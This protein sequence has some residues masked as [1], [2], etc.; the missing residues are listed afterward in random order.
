VTTVHESLAAFVRAVAACR[1]N[2]SQVPGESLPQVCADTPLNKLSAGRGI[3]HLYLSFDKINHKHKYKGKLGFC[4]REAFSLAS[5]DPIF[6]YCEGYAS[7]EALSI[8]LHHA[9]CVNRET[10]E[11]Y[12]PVWN[13]KKVRGNAYCGLPFN[14]KFA[15]EVVLKTKMYGVL[16]MLWSCGQ[17]TLAT[18]ISDIIHPAYHSVFLGD[19]V[20]NQ[21]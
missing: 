14:I 8:P 9:W 19:S 7:S 17:D 16:D 13:S 2:M 10:Q 12:D 18:P 3:E 5:R 20:V 1:L 6:I 15:L 21:A 11:V 4:F